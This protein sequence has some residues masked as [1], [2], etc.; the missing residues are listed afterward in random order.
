MMAQGIAEGALG[1][2]QLFQQMSGQ[3]ADRQ[4]QRRRLDQYDRQL[5]IAQS[6]EDRALREDRVKADINN[7]NQNMLMTDSADFFDVT[8]SRLDKK[9]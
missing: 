1:A 2:L 7:A 4:M 8:K 6:A 5:E 9:K 3:R